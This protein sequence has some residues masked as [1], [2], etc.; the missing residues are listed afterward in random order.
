MAFINLRFPSGIIAEI[1]ANERPDVVA[2][3]GDVTCT[4]PAALAAAGVRPRA[5]A[6]VT[7]HRPSNVDDAEQLDALVETLSRVGERLPVLWPGRPTHTRERLLGRRRLRALERGGRVALR[8]SLACTE[9]LAQM[10]QAMT[11]ESANRLVDPYDGEAIVGALNDVLAA[12]MP[13]PMRPELWDGHAAE[14][15]VAVIDEWAAS[16]C[17]ARRRCGLSTCRRAGRHRACM[18]VIVFATGAVRVGSVHV[19]SRSPS[20]LR[21]LGVQVDAVLCAHATQAGP[22]AHPR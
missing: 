22:G 9:F 19:E 4:L 20:P 12:P 8:A 1:Q 14:R 3:V 6:L 13:A 17:Q 18:I 21:C 5:C 15:I 16:R 2:A 10:D 7:L 11:T